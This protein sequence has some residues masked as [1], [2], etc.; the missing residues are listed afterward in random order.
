MSSYEYGHKIHSCQIMVS[1]VIKEHCTIR[2]SEIKVISLF[3]LIT[4]SNNVLFT[5]YAHSQFKRSPFIPTPILLLLF[6][7][8]LVTPTINARAFLFGGY[9]LKQQNLYLHF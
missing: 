9:K 8:A 2:Y 7:T 1:S 5:F 6:N 3:I 4:F